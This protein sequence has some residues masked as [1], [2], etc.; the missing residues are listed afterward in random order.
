MS[1]LARIPVA[2]LRVGDVLVEWETTVDRRIVYGDGSVLV[3]FTNG[4]ARSFS[5]RACVLRRREWAS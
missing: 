1:D 2:D 3:Y 5:A 4:P